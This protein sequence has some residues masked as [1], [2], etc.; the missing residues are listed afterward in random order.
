MA[1]DIELIGPFVTAAAEVLRAEASV[2]VNRGQLSLESAGIIT[3]DV[4]TL[5]SVVGDA[6]GLVLYNLSLETC[7]ALVGR[8]VGQPFRELDQLAQSGIAELGNVMAGRAVTKLSA[9]GIQ[10]DISVPT[11]VMGRGTSVSAPSI[12]RLVVPLRTELGELEVHLALRR[13]RG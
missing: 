4:A 1:M 7:L 10:A 5:L 11:M 6:E 2:E 3:S 9:A 13:R 12:Q 8:M